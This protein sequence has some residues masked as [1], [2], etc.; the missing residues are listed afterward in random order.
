[1]AG[2]KIQVIRITVTQLSLTPHRTIFSEHAADGKLTNQKLLGVFSFFGVLLFWNLPSL[3]VSQEC[4]MKAHR[5]SVCECAM[6]LS[7]SFGEL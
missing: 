5:L 3:Q 1:M 6:Q 2:S 4:V 7:G